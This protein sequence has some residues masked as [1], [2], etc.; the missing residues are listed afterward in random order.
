MDAALPLPP[1][2]V[3]AVTRRVNPPLLGFVIGAAVPALVASVAWW[4]D[5]PWVA[6]VAAVGIPIGALFAAVVAPRMVGADWVGATLLAALAAPLVPAAVI[7]IGFLAGS[8][9]TA[10]GTGPDVLLGGVYVAVIALVVGELIGA[11]IT[12]PVA[13]IVALLIRRAFGMPERRALAHVGALAVVTIAVGLVT[14]AAA[15][16]LLVPYG[17]G[18][19]DP[20][21]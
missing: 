3:T 8:V 10:F 20:G 15:T 21:Y 14:I 16:G 13:F 1:L 6:Y 7:A 2:P 17:I 11:P 19:V 18:R 12:L 5:V 9:A 4:L